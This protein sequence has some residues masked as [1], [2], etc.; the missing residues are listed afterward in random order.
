[1]KKEY[2]IID[3]IQLLLKNKFIF[4]IMGISSLIISIVVSYN[5]PVYYKST[6]ILYPYNPEAYDPRNID[7]AT[8]PYGSSFDGDRIMAIAES[9]DI[10]HYIIDKYDLIKRYNIDKKD[11]MADVKVREI[12]NENLSISENQYSAIEI[13]LMDFNPDTAAIIVNDIVSKIDDLNKKPL[14]EMNKKI[15]ETNERVINEKY[16]GI[17][18][19]QKLKTRIYNNTNVQQ[20]DILVLEAMNVLSELNTSRKRLELIK[21][22]LTTINVIQHAEA[23]NK[24]ASPKRLIIIVISVTISLFITF[25]VLL[26]ID[27]YNRNTELN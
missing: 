23:I 13:S 24:K 11:V 12:F 15:F 14:L 25:L 7:R 27:L 20:T 10:H 2:N 1:M 22:N 26:S 17:D 18:S 3:L 5:L 8:S 16:N 6:S 21:N 9:R 4:L 19:I